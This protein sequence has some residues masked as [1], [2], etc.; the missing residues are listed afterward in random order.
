MCTMTSSHRERERERNEREERQEQ[1]QGIRQQ[2]RRRRPKKL[3]KSSNFSLC[4]LT[5]ELSSC[6]GNAPLAPTHT[7]TPTH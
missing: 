2:Q 4:D 7:H 3:M 5:N 1:G 6:I